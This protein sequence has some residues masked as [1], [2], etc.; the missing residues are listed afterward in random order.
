[1]TDPA[2]VVEILDRIGRDEPTTYDR[3]LYV[4]QPFPYDLE[5]HPIDVRSVSKL[6]PLFLDE[7][8]T[9]GG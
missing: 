1:M 7:S 8:A 2:Y 6:K 4:E 5:A 3:L 9:T